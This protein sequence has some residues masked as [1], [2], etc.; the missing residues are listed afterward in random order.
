MNQSVNLSIYQSVS[1]YRP[2]GPI[3]CHR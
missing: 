3:C 2:I 1:N